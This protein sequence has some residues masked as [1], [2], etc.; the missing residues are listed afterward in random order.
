MPLHHNSIDLEGQRFGRLVAKTPVRK[1]RHRVSWV[2]ACD[3]GGQTEVTTSDLRSG[4]TVSCGCWRREASIGNRH[5]ITHG[6]SQ[7][8]TYKTWRSMRNRCESPNAGN[9]RRYGGRGVTVCARWQEFENFLADM[10]PRPSLRHQIDRY[11]DKHGN[12]EPG[13]CRWATPR[14]NSQ[15]RSNNRLVELNGEARPVAA[16]AQSAGIAAYTLLQRLNR[17]WT[18]EEAMRVPAAKKAP[19]FLTHAGRT[20]TLTEWAVELGVNHNTLSA[21]IRLGWDHERALTT[22]FNQTEY[23]P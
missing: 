15:N 16:W 1:R 22:P 5:S 11:P 3:C 12:Y 18:L 14:E 2:C 17:G 10:G 20:Q 7:T 8:S 23:V 4:H 6:M 13:N 9:Y 19:R 21:R